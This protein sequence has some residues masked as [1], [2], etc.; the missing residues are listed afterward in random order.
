M[1]GDTGSSI[2][3]IYMY[4]YSHICKYIHLKNS[5]GPA[6]ICLP[7]FSPWVTQAIFA[8]LRELIIRSSLQQ[9][10]SVTHEVISD[11]SGMICRMLFKMLWSFER[12]SRLPQAYFSRQ[13]RVPGISLHV[14]SLPR[15]FQLP[16]ALFG[17]TDRFLG[18][19]A[20]SGNHSSYVVLSVFCISIQKVQT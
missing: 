11:A 10:L 14:I 17:E 6:R 16:Q 2:C 3:N 13:K 8:S 1:L 5:I 12:S 7:C 15:S 18:F 4:I 9:R 20:T 19:Y